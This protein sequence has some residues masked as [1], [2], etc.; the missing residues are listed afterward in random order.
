M[1][2]SFLTA[3][4]LA[5]VDNAPNGANLNLS[6]HDTRGLNS[7]SVKSFFFWRSLTFFSAAGSILSQLKVIICLEIHDTHSQNACLPI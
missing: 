2:Q 4:S 1:T 7:R 6:C 5:Q 3:A